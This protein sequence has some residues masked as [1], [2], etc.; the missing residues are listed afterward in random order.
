MTPAT[1]DPIEYPKIKL[2]GA[3]YE[4]RWRLSDVVRLKKTASIDIFDLKHKTLCAEYVEVIAALIAHGVA[5]SLAITPDEVMEQLQF[6]RFFE[7]DAVIAAAIK[8]TSR[9]PMA[10]SPA[11]LSIEATGSSIG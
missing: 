2:N 7:F 4:V 11:P 3:E 10:E 6:D 9:P 1:I 8:K 5:H